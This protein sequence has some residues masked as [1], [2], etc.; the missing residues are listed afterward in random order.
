MPRN[1][2]T[3]KAKYLKNWY[4]QNK[5]LFLMYCGFRYLANKDNKST[6]SDRYPDR[7]RK[8]CNAWKKRNK[9]ANAKKHR[10]SCKKWRL[11]VQDIKEH[12]PCEDCQ[13]YFPHYQMEFDHCYGIKWK[14]PSIWAGYGLVSLMLAEMMLCELV[15]KNC[16]GKRTWKRRVDETNNRSF[17]KE[18]V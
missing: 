17:E 4:K 16:H 12:T 6:Y 11:L 18:A 8:S 3:N 15:C 9:K 13:G 5:E 2:R 14:S 10:E 1:R 7:A